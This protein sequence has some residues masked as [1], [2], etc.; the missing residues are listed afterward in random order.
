MSWCHLC[1]SCHTTILGLVHTRCSQAR[2][3]FSIFTRTILQVTIIP[4]VHFSKTYFEIRNNFKIYKLKLKL[5]LAESV[6]Q[7]WRGRWRSKGVRHLLPRQPP[8]AARNKLPAVLHPGDEHHPS[9]STRRP[10]ARRRNPLL[11]CQLREGRSWSRSQS[12]SRKW[13]CSRSMI[14]GRRHRS[15]RK[16]TAAGRNARSSPDRYATMFQKQS[17]QLLKL[18]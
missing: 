5:Y 13:R 14:C 1:N 9:T 3:P 12:C 15:K 6:R 4:A 7:S 8:P 17:F 16:S 18:L 10:A 2:P 11:L